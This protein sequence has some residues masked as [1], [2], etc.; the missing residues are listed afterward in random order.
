MPYPSSYVSD[1]RNVPAEYN[2]VCAADAAV[3]VGGTYV[4]VASLGTL[5]PGQYLISGSVY[6]LNGAGAAFVNS[7]FL[8]GTTPYAGTEGSCIATG[9]IQL[10]TGAFPITIT[11]TAGAVV[12]LQCTSTTATGSIKASTTNGGAVAGASWISA[13]RIK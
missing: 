4:D 10:T 9:A 12:K 2:A 13:V 1:P 6:F 5:P 8:V 7:K 11:A 3:G